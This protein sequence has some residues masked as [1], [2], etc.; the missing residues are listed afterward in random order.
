MMLNKRKQYEGIRHISDSPVKT[1]YVCMSLYHIGVMWTWFS[2][3]HVY[4]G[5]V[6]FYSKIAIT[7]YGITCYGSNL[8]L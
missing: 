2:S 1:Y 4:I 8:S 6:T 7:Y 3:V 5:I